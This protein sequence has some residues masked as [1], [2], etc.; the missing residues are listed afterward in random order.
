L[1]KIFLPDYGVLLTELLRIQEE[2]NQGS[3]PIIGMVRG[4]GLF[5]GIELVIDIETREP[6][7]DAASL[8]V[9]EMKRVGILLS[10]DGPDENVIKFKPPMC[11]TMEN[12]RELV[13]KLESV[14]PDL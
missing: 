10:T 2:E 1:G 13:A 7:P 8:M 4:V 9:N 12:A 5:I 11:F 6:N 3:N 14:L